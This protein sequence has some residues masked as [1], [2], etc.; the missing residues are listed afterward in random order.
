MMHNKQGV[1]RDVLADDKVLETVQEYVYLG[2]KT[3]FRSDI[4]PESFRTIKVEVLRM[5]KDTWKD[6]KANARFHK[7]RQKK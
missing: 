3:K 5:Y 2:Q 1:T 7:E 4:N 6:G